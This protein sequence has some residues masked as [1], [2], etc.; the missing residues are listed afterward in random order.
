MFSETM[1]FI[2]WTVIS[3]SL[4]AIVLLFLTA[5]FVYIIGYYWTLGRHKALL[6]AFRDREKIKTNA[7][8]PTRGNR[9]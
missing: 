2:I 7:T 3:W 4:A 6:T 8:E 9:T 5:M 1:S